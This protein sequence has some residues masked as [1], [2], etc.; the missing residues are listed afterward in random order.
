MKAGVVAGFVLALAAPS[1]CDAQDE[2][3]F[4]KKLAEANDLLAERR[5]QEVVDELSAALEAN[6]GQ[7]YVRLH[8]MEITDSVRRAKFHLAHEPLAL[9]ESIDGKLKS[10][11]AATGAIEIHYRPGD[12]EEMAE[13]TKPKVRLLP[14]WFTGTRSLTLE[15][16]QYPSYASAGVQLGLTDGVHVILVECGRQGGDAV[17]WKGRL[18]DDYKEGRSELGRGPSTAENNQP[19]ALR[20]DV[21]EA[22]LRLSIADAPVV[23]VEIPP[24][25]R[26][27]VAEKIVFDRMVVVGAVRADSI[28]DRIAAGFQD[29]YLEFCNRFDA[30]KELPKWLYEPLSYESPHFRDEI[31]SA[32]GPN[33]RVMAQ[34]VGLLDAGKPEEALS[35]LDKAKG[36]KGKEYRAWIRAQANMKLERPGEV[37]RWTREL[38]RSAKGFMEGRMLAVSAL[39]KLGRWSDA[40]KELRAILKEEP[41]YQAAYF[42]IVPTLLRMGAAEEAREYVERAKKAGLRVAPDLESMLV[43]ALKGPVWSSIESLSTAHYDIHTNMDPA[44][45]SVAADILESGFER[46]SDEIAPAKR[47]SGQRYQVY[48]FASRRGYDVYTLGHLSTDARHTLGVFFGALRQ[49]LAFADA[50][51]EEFLR[52]IRHEGFHQFLD[53]VEIDVPVWLNEG[54]AAYYEPFGSDVAE[55]EIPVVDK[56]VRELSERM[57]EVL[58]LER[59]LAWSPTDFRETGFFGYSQAWA[60]VHFMRSAP[61]RSKILDSYFRKLRKGEQ[62][63]SAMEK[64]FAKVDLAELNRAFRAHIEGLVQAK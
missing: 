27:F 16:A 38:K 41:G 26:Y 3:R 28:Q 2:R 7:D 60:F 10:Y 40:A 39:T 17:V 48:L 25:F 32:T 29:S 49:L 14:F 53:S 5:W 22:R 9:E 63:E 15:G 21:E 24:G 58:V 47:Q 55:G 52:T 51:H 8:R 20:L 50:D 33:A 34:A 4:K 59:I 46:Y 64:T 61:D 19:Y 45:L 35:A 42:A 6:S 43:M 37:L 18:G 62:S 1:F 31:P 12:L 57:D 13:A 23:E 30:E 36:S 11:D 56:H 54:L 44:I